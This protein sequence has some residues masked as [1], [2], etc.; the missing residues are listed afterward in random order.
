MGAL[1]FLSCL[2]SLLSV[3]CHLLVVCNLALLRYEGSLIVASIV[4]LFL[5]MKY[6]LRHVREKKGEGP[7]L[8]EQQSKPQ[9]LRR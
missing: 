7:L 4:T 6:V 8:N 3:V 1:S 5:L 9:L 2:L